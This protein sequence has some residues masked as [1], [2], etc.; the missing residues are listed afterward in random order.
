MSM[1]SKPSDDD[2]LDLAIFVT[3]NLIVACSDFW[4]SK[5]SGEIY[6]TNFFWVVNC[7]RGLTL[8]AFPSHLQPHLQLKGLTP[9]FTARRGMY[10]VEYMI[11]R[12]RV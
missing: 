9:A 2:D 7:S 11:T 8:V 3:K 12:Y 6:K 4:L 5:W 10:G 1:Y